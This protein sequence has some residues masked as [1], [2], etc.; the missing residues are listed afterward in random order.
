MPILMT[1][2]GW[3]FEPVFARK[4][5]KN[6]SQIEN[7]ITFR[8]EMLLQ[9]KLYNNNNK[10]KYC[11]CLAFSDILSITTLAPVTLHT[12]HNQFV[13]AIVFQKYKIK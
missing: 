1:S 6:R 7:G 12:F 13:F 4:I 9:G 2:A 10:V 5:W 11:V 8:Q 3:P